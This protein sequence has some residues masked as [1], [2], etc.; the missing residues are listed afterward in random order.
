MAAIGVFLAIAFGLLQIAAGFIG[1]EESIGTGWAWAALIATFVFRFT[2]PLTV[3]AFLC[4]MN[5]WEWHWLAAAAFAAPGLLFIIP[6]I[7]GALAS[8]RRGW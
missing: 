2:L 8:S 5:V 7:F 1:I 3:G 4:A 6:G